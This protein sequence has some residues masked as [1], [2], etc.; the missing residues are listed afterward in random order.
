MGIG[1]AFQVDIYVQWIL[2]VFSVLN[3]L[4]DWCAIYFRIFL[5]VFVVKTCEKSFLE[6][7]IHEQKDSYMFGS[8][9]R[10]KLA[11][12]YRTVKQ[13]HEKAY[14]DSRQWI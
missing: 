13:D 11:M 12:L 7:I 4:F 5:P 3:L 1:L 14:Y 9:L 6:I 8:S 2:K 10:M